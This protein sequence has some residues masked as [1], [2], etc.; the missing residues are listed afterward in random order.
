MKKLFKAISLL[1]FLFSVSL[2]QGQVASIVKDVN[3]GSVSSF[4]SSDDKVVAYIGDRTLFIAKGPNNNSNLYST[5]GTAAGTFVLQY[6]TSG[7]IYFRDFTPAGS[8][9]AYVWYDQGVSD[10]RLYTTDG[11]TSNWLDKKPSYKAVSN[12][13]FY[14]DTLFYTFLNELRKIDLQNAV[15]LLVHQAP[16]GNYFN[17][18]YFEDP[19]TLYYATITSADDTLFVRNL[20]TSS[21]TKLGGIG[22]AIYKGLYFNK[23]NGKLLF[24]NEENNNTTSFYSTDGTPAGTV[25]LNR[26]YSGY[27]SNFYLINNNKLYF[28]A[29]L[30][31]GDPNTRGYEIWSSDGTIGG[32]ISLYSSTTKI[33]YVKSAVVYGGYVYFVAQEAN[34]F[35]TYLYKTDGSQAG[36]S[37]VLASTLQPYQDLNTIVVLNGDMYIAAEKANPNNVGVEI[38]KTDGTT[39]GTTLYQTISGSASLFYEHLYAA[40]NQLFFVGEKSSTG[41]ELYVCSLTITPTIGEETKNLF[42]CYPNPFSEQLNIDYQGSEPITSVRLR[43]VNGKLIQQSVTTETLNMIQLAP[44]FYTL[45]IETS[46]GVEVLKVQKR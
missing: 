44:G 29:M 32:T 5:D 37:K 25:L 9:V 16:I 18:F 38:W 46:N 21:E 2:L 6:A 39:G 7:G 42:S 4:N 31:L 3:T 11:L 24:F 13:K 14:N 41:R 40:S 20:T 43:N 30:D 33:D 10:Y 27:E 23:V 36:T 34:M 26:Y 35:E 12:L 15:D 17:D 28:S 8:V 45:E 19:N 22:V 1:T